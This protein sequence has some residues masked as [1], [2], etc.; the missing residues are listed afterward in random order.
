MLEVVKIPVF[1]ENQ[2]NPEYLRIRNDYLLLTKQYQI[3]ENGEFIG[4]MPVTLENDCF[5]PLLRTDSNN[6]F[7]Y[8]MTL[9]LDGERYLLFLNYYGEFYLVDRNIN[10]YYFAIEGNRLPRIDPAVVKPFL[11]DGELIKHSND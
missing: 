4:G 11:L 1:W 5:K 9:K 8:N 2:N 6:R 10:F 7:A 3:K